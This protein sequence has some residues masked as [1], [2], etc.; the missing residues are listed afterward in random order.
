MIKKYLNKVPSDDCDALGKALHY[1]ID[2][3]M[4]LH[5]SGFGPSQTP[6]GLLMAVEAYV[7]HIQKRYMPTGA[8][9]RRWI[10]GT[11]LNIATAMANRSNM[12]AKP[13]ASALLKPGPV[14]TMAPPMCKQTYSGYCFA[15][16]AN[17]DSAI[18]A[19]LQDAYQSVASWLYSLSAMQN[20]SWSSAP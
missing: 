13:L 9:D 10:A 12:F 15:N 2:I 8:W 16:D 7:P 6:K 1:V 14:C 20:F 11:P 3:T 4:P 19:S 17:V 18:G 5:T